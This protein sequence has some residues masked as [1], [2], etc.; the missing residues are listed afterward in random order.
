MDRRRVGRLFFPFAFFFFVFIL[1][2]QSESAEVDWAAVEQEVG[3][4][5]S[6]YIR[7]D[8]TNP[9][10]NETA[11]ALFWK[12]VLAKDGLEAQV[13]ESQPGRG[14]VYA[15]L[16]G[17]GEKKALILLHHLDVVPAVK[18]DWEVDPFAGIVK[19][20]YVHGRGAIDCKG[21]AVT[22]FVSLA[23]LKRLG[24]PFRQP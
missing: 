14:V 1:T 21:V 16:K 15:R 6:R 22:Q 5:L 18:A 19:D 13:L 9:P 8:T 23:L 4:L 10:G 24:V 7:I 11:A 12:E 20:G 17:S 2:I 3:D